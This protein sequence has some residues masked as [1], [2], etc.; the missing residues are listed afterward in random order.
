MLVLK[1]FRND[2]ILIGDDIVIT[3][4]E[5]THDGGVKLGITAPREMIV[6]REEVRIKRLAGEPYAGRREGRS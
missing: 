2:R 5:V 3:V 1:R 6:D 4:V